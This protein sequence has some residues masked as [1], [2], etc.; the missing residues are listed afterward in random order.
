MPAY[1]SKSVEELRAEDYAVR[2]INRGEG[3][4]CVL[5]F[6]FGFLSN[7]LPRRSEDYMAHAALARTPTCDTEG[8]A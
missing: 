7:V 8:I 2:F 6:V 5:L 1:V 3:S 4:F